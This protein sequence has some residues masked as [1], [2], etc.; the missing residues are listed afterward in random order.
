MPQANAPNGQA[1]VT[2]CLTVIGVFLFLIGLGC[3]MAGLNPNQPR[4]V[5]I[6]CNVMMVV[7]LVVGIVTFAINKAMKDKQ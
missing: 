5:D 1:C 7:G 6:G 2:G 3:N 4:D